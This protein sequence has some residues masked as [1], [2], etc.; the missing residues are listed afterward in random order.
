MASSFG[1]PFLKHAYDIVSTS[2]F[3]NLELCFALSNLTSNFDF[4]YVIKL[5]PVSVKSNLT[6]VISF[7]V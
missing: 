2:T 6:I 4:K 5:L 3:S 1:N 7:I